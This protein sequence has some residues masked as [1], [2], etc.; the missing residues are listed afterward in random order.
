MGVKKS[1]KK[2]ERKHI[3]SK[4]YEQGRNKKRDQKNYR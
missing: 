3:K 1:A 4:G 2:Q